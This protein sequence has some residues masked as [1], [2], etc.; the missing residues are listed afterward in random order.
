MF[1]NLQEP[2]RILSRLYLFYICVYN[3][4]AEDADARKQRPWIGKGV[5]DTEHGRC[6]RKVREFIKYS[7]FFSDVL[8]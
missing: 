1:I 8:K 3:N 2:L 7:Q 6:Q 5:G 4:N